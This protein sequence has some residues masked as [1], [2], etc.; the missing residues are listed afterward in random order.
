MVKGGATNARALSIALN[1]PELKHELKTAQ[2]DCVTVQLHAGR[3]ANLP[4]LGPKEIPV[5]VPACVYIPKLPKIEVS[6]VD[7]TKLGLQKGQP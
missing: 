4:G 2:R 5:D 1:L 6:D 7:M 3:Y